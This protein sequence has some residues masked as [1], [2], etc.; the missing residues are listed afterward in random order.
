MNL[1]GY[2]PVVPP[3]PVSGSGPRLCEVVTVNTDGTVDVR[4]LKSRATRQRVPGLSGWSP[5]V[6]DRVI[7]AALDGD[8]QAPAVIAVQRATVPYGH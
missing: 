6:G 8:P 3:T 1:H 5:T 4:S 2:G 7:V